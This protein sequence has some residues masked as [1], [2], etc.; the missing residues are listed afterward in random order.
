MAIDNS[1]NTWIIARNDDKIIFHGTFSSKGS[2][3]E[4]GTIKFDK[5]GIQEV[6]S[7]CKIP[8]Q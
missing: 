3:D 1:S 7:L 5:K 2:F 8:Y 6:K 4:K